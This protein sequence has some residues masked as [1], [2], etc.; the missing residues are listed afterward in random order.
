MCVRVFNYNT[1]E[2]CRSLRRTSTT[3]GTSSR[4]RQRLT[5]LTA[6][7]DMTVK[8]WDWEKGWANTHVF[9]G[10]GHYVMMVKFNPK[11]HN[12][13]A[14]ASLDRTVKVWSLGSPIPNFSLEGHERGVNCIDYYQGGDKP[15]L[16]SGADD[17]LIKIWDYQTKSCVQ[18][19]EGHTNNVSAVCFHTSLPVIL[20]ACEDGTVRIW[21]STT[22]RLESTLNYGLERCWTLDV[23]KGS[24]KVAAGYDEGTVVVKLGHEVPVLSMDKNGK[25]VMAVNNDIVASAVR[26]YVKGCRRRDAVV[27]PIQR[28]WLV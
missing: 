12:T 1:L 14:S 15:Y 13:F 9:E 6:S 24:S 16:L 22:Y 8:L 26:G 25:I 5:C 19:L 18:T 4:I 27:P 3:S 2:K 23:A 10:H 11:D 20:S 7:D 17:S 21:H 28:S